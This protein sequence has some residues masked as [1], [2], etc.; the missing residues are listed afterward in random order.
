VPRTDS[1]APAKPGAGQG[2]GLG[3]RGE[4]DAVVGGGAGG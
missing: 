4:D 2:A 3:K 1:T